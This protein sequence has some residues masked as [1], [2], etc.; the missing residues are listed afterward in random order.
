MSLS[1]IFFCFFF[2]IGI[3]IPVSPNSHPPILTPIFIAIL[4]FLYE[5]Y[6]NNLTV[7]SF[8][9]RTKLFMLL[10][11][12][13][14]YVRLI[15]LS[16]THAQDIHV[17]LRVTLIFHSAFDMYHNAVR[18]RFKKNG[19]FLILIGGHR[20]QRSIPLYLIDPIPHIRLI[21]MK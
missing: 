1:T 11:D 16:S 2:R 12:R 7:I 4:V 19:R 20:L 18:A 8:S 13:W 9:F 15:D 6:P 10:N 17:K 14:P 21:F 5:Q 3:K